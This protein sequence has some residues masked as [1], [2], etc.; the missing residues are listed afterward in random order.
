VT[1]ADRFR[2]QLG[3][4]LALNRLW[5]DRFPEFG[6]ESSIKTPRRNMLAMM[7]AGRSLALQLISAD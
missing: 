6:R 3:K 5:K 4:H 1:L 7:P 2:G